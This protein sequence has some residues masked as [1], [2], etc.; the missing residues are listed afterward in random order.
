MAIYQECT[1]EPKWIQ[2]RA[3]L[4]LRNHLRS[5]MKP[6][7][8]SMNQTEISS[9]RKPNIGQT[10][11]FARRLRLRAMFVILVIT[12]HVCVPTEENRI[13]HL[14][15]LDQ[16]SLRR[17]LRH[18]L[19]TTQAGAQFAAAAQPVYNNAS[20]QSANDVV[21][22]DNVNSSRIMV[23]EL[24]DLNFARCEVVTDFSICQGNGE[25]THIDVNHVNEV[26]YNDDNDGNS[27][28]RIGRH[29]H[30][31][32]PLNIFQDS[33]VQSLLE[34]LVNRTRW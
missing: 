22:V 5:N 30:A 4:Q 28:I 8:A 3:I 31:K 12:L 23:N 21:N 32:W 13:L 6:R 29:I 19:P 10:R 26:N 34:K 9:G 16:R 7:R 17:R 15:I 11:V 33:T 20:T 27:L 25:V 14:A 1:E 18:C 24:V 2:Q